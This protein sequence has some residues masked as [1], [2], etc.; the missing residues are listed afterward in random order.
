LGPYYFLLN[1]ELIDLGKIETVTHVDFADFIVEL[2]NWAINFAALFAVIMIVVAGF[3]YIVSMGDEK[4][5][6]AA[7]RSLIFS[8]LGIILVF[9]APSVI[10]FILSNFLGI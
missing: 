5:I 3:Q 2:L 1:M 9:F 8:L 6:A 4:K 7:N 10:K